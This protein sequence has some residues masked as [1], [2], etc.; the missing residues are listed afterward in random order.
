MVVD[1]L[2][3]CDEPSLLVLR[4]LA[5]RLD[6]APVLVLATYRD[7]EPGTGL[8]AM[9]P[10]LL[11][12]PAAARL[13]PRGLDLD[14]VRDQLRS[15]G[16]GERVDAGA[17]WEATGGN[18]LFVREIARAVADGSWRPDRVP[19]SV[20]DVVAARV[21][22]LSA[23]CREFLQAAAV[24]GVRFD[25]GMVAAVLDE[26]VGA[27]AERV[28]EASARG[29]LDRVDDT[30]G[31][32][33]LHAL[34]RD[35]VVASLDT[36]QRLALHR[37]AATALQERHAGDVAD[38]LGEIARHWSALA[39]YG[40]AATARTWTVAA[41]D[42]A[43]RRLA[44][45]QA[46]ALYRTAL[47][48]PAPWPDPAARHAVQ[49]ALGRA[50]HLA[51]DLDAAVDAAAAAAVTARAAGRA[52]LLAEAALVLD[53]V[54]DPRVNA[55][56][57]D[58]CAQALLA[59]G[60]DHPALR[61][62]L[63]ALRSALAFYA[64]DRDA[65]RVDSATALEL[66]R[67]AGDDTALV[68]ALRARL[69]ACPGPGGVDERLALADAMA[70]VADRTGDAHAALWARLWRVDALMEAGAV[71]AAAEQLAPLGRAAAR[72]GGPVATWHD[73]RVQACV[74]Q[75]RGRFA[76]AEATSLRAFERMRGIETAAAVG[77]RLGL[78]CA[79]ARHAGTPEVGVALARSALPAPPRFAAMSGLARAYLLLR[80]GL[81]DE[82]AA[83]YQQAGDPRS[84]TWPVF[85]VAHGHTLAVLLAAGLDR[86]ADLRVAL[87]G[88]G[89]FRGQFVAGGGVNHH[90]P[91]ELTLGFGA[92]ALGRLDVAVE[93]LGVAL[94]RADQAGTP[95]FTAEA[96]HHLAVALAAR[97]A[98]GD[99]ERAHRVAV[100]SDR[101]VRALGMAPF[102][103]P[104][105]EL[106]RRLGGGAGGLSARE[107]Q[108]AELVGEGLTN[109]Q[110]AA[111]L[112]ISERTAGNHVQHVLTKLGFGSRS[113]IAAWT[114]TRAVNTR[115][116]N[117]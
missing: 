67:T 88:L 29:L 104:S 85:F 59:L 117:R 77:A 84:W 116:V 53:A 15:L 7:T 25:P 87:D 3:W 96:G 1:D 76:E 65:T 107:A 81:P 62:R 46:V 74:A 83:V 12:A 110:I 42:E 2:H 39:G 64:D 19:G 66:A 17:V 68:A 36:A 31:L 95:G 108:V 22:R 52:D 14:A 79:L 13:Q 114:A 70:R 27:C 97:G 60:E 38:H 23:P 30:G 47:A 33:F 40:E 56:T 75:A 71:T 41:G 92:L 101:L 37:A 61:A 80:A 100:E 16:A 102:L 69:D 99:R 94:A 34:T 89:A 112:V 63:L 9:L 20:R 73:D 78:L 49:I 55:G 86:A 106:M 28:D 45:E 93:D 32:R 21:A 48:L 24:V 8:A 54:T 50:A 43:V 90:G 91:A 35:A 103:G 57:A 111:R 6:T 72:V 82:A 11:R 109:R 105:A 115:A 44:F 10:D 58:L 98:P 26:P 4:H 51:G 18:P 5:G 113:Q